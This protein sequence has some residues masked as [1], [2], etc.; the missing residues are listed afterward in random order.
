M[1]IVAAIALDTSNPLYGTVSQKARELAF[2]V[3]V[4]RRV[5]N[6]FGI[7]QLIDPKT[8]VSTQ[9]KLSSKILKQYRRGEDGPDDFDLP[10][11]EDRDDILVVKAGGQNV[12]LDGNHR[13][14]GALLDGRKIEGIVV[15]LDDLA[16]R[17]ADIQGPGEDLGLAIDRLIPGRKTRKG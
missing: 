4:T 12:V 5:M 15:D 9:K 10:H 6:A 8:V 7:E 2:D 16:R 11:N 13:L 14:A 3:G 1:K 17:A